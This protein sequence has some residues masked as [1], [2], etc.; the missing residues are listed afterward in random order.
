MNCVLAAGGGSSG[1]FG[2]LW[3]LDLV[4]VS[5]CLPLRLFLSSLEERGGS[6]LLAGRLVCFPRRNGRVK[7]AQ[8]YVERAL[9]DVRVRVRVRVSDVSE[10]GE[11]DLPG[12]GKP[13]KYGW[14]LVVGDYVAIYTYR[15]G[16]AVFFPFCF[17]FRDAFFSGNWEQRG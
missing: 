8:V 14:L 1:R 3:P 4:Y 16:L 9:E 10:E 13:V 5:I 11:I 17:C 12:F 15:Q 2:S 7:R 6:L